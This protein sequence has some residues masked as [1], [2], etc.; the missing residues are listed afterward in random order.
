MYYVLIGH[1]FKKR[2]ITNSASNMGSSLNSESRLADLKKHEDSLTWSQDP[3]T[4][5][6]LQRLNQM[7]LN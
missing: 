2:R 3:A 6:C 4:E 1:V 7:L 5:H